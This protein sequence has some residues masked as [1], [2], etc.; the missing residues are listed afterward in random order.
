MEC[1]NEQLVENI[2]HY[3]EC[4]FTPE[5]VALA[6]NIREATAA[7]LPAIQVSRNEGRLLYLIAKIS[8]G[9]RF[10]EIGTLAGYSTTWLARALPPE[11]SLVTLECV[12]EHAEVARRNLDRAGVARQVEI[13]LGA[14]SD[15][16]RELIRSRTEPFDLIFIDADKIGYVEYLELALQLSRPGTIILADNVIRHGQVLDPD[17]QDPDD[18]AVRAYNAAIASHPRLESLILPIIRHRIDG[19]AISIVK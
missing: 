8:G 13:L 16:L 15:S 12:P 6:Q 4:L 7:G 5:D 11:G 10:L 18:R 3:I 17:P 14:A 19:L 2:D 1:I 9:R